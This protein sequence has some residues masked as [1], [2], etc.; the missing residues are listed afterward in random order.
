MQE[1]VALQ[2]FTKEPRPGHVKTRLHTVLEPAESAALHASLTEAC[3]RRFLHLP[4]WFKLEIW[5]DAPASVDFYSGLLKRYPR[6]R[7]RRQR[8][9][10]LGM[11]M[12]F[13]FN[14]GLLRHRGV[15]LTGTDCPLLD[16]PHV[17]DV[18]HQLDSQRINLIEAEDGGYVLIA[19]RNRHSGIFRGITWGTS[20]VLRETA[21]AI[22]R[23]GF[24]MRT[25]GRLWDIDDESDLIRYRAMQQGS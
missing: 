21:A 23:S 4:G 22:R 8:G 5:G 12:A 15:I 25:H 20:S 17:L 1:S 3:I 24:E 7:F 16:A 6:L 18:Y 2:I 13:A 10:D 19:G 9:R 14:S 11:R